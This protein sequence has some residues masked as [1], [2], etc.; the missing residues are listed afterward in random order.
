M[1]HWFSYDQVATFDPAT[2]SLTFFFNSQATFLSIHCDITSQILIMIPMK[3]FFVTNF[4]KLIN[5]NTQ[6]H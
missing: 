6:V 3:Y 5:V 4:L 2:P 1:I